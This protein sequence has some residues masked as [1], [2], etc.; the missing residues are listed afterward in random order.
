M[1]GVAGSRP[2]EGVKIQLLTNVRYE[3]LMYVVCYLPRD[4]YIAELTGF[5]FFFFF[6]RTSLPSDKL[7][8]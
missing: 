1:P 7:F 3:L 6:R 4:V 2:H 5:F 8:S